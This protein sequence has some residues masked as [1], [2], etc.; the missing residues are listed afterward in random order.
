VKLLKNLEVGSAKPVPAIYL[1]AAQSLGVEPHYLLFVG[2][3]SDDELAG[4]ERAGL[5]PVLVSSTTTDT[6]DPERPELS[7][8]EGLVL[9]DLSGVLSLLG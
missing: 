1:L 9:E 4:A 5:R 2:D 3:G 7:S 6:Y 8:W